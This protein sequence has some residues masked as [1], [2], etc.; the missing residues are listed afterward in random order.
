MPYNALTNGGN[1]YLDSNSKT[2]RFSG[3]ILSGPIM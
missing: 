2:K 1:I 3:N